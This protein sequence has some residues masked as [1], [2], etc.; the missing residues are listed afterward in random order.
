MLCAGCRTAVQKR[1]ISHER[2]YAGCQEEKLPDGHIFPVPVEDKGI[3]CA[4]V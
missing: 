4:A 1:Y 3:S 2:G